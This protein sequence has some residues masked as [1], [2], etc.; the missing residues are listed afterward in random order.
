[1][2]D[3]DE[4]D[5]IK[6]ES[7]PKK[8]TASKKSAIGA[9]IEEAPKLKSVILKG[10]APV[11]EKC[12]LASSYH[13]F[14]DSDGVWDTMLNQADLKKN[15]NKFYIIQLLEKDSGQDFR[16]WTRWGRVGENGQSNLY[17]PP[18]ETSS[19]SIENA[20][21]QF[22]NK[23]R[24][25]TKNIWEERKFFV[26]Q[27]GKYD[28]VALDYCQQ[29]STS[30][31]IKD[32]EPLLDSVLPLEVQQLVKLVCSLQT[33]EKA[34]MELQYDT[35]KVPLG[36]LT[37][38]QI[39]AGYRALNVVS[40]CVNKGLR[41]G[42]ELT[43]AC[44][45]FYT[46]IPHVSGR[47]KL[48]LLTSKEMV[49][50]KIQ[51]LEALQ[52]IEVALRLLGGSCAGGNLVDE[53]YNRLQVNIQPVPA[54]VLRATIESSILSTH[55]DT[56]S[57]YRMAVEDLFSLGKPSETENF[58]DCGNKQLLFHGSRLSNWAGIL[59]Q[60]LRIAP[61]E[62]P[63]TG[64]MF[65]KGEKLSALCLLC[66]APDVGVYFAD[67]SSK[68]ANYCFPSRSQP[69]GLL[70]VCEVSTGVARELVQA[71]P[72]ADKLLKGGETRRP[73]LCGL[74]EI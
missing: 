71:D 3:E 2:V 13:V 31:I 53:N 72:R 11:D 36:K 66:S 22:A 43:E 52:D 32:E 8:S 60:G 57:Q 45:I 26:K 15:N 34:V 9:E 38:E 17:P 25:K 47:S 33:M 55:A 21:K 23:F 7:N 51:L 29:E 37:P 49:K 10:K 73:I 41:E 40:E 30:A 24:D 14:S 61:P 18:T 4:Q 42:D 62:A 58:M 20:K 63:V 69:H 19:L 59:G 48:P 35:K 46:R 39:T 16:V 68:A 44:N 67:M 50:E 27:A 54:G 64:Y 74:A 65:G 28:M 70:L 1:M 5:G 6:E 12:P 56:H